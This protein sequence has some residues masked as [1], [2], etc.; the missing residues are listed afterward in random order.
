MS[1]QSDCIVHKFDVSGNTVYH[2]V[3]ISVKK[4]YVNNISSEL[5]Y[6][7]I[8]QPM[9]NKYNYIILDFEHYDDYSDEFLYD[10]KGYISD[11]S[12]NNIKTINIY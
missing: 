1:F 5:F 9:I 6:S 7:N 10:L 11:F 3:I 4:C 8:F 12:S 2:N